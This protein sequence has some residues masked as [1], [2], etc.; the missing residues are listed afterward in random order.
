MTIA[1]DN[2]QRTGYAAE[3]VANAFLSLARQEGRAL[4]QM[5]VH[6]L[7]FI[8]H[9]FTL[10]LLGRPLMYNTVHAWRG[11][12]VVRR[13]WQLWGERGTRPI[14]EALP[15]APGEPDLGGDP[16]A[17]DVIRSVWEAYG[18]MDGLELSRLT[19]RSGSPWSQVYGQPTDLIPDQVTREY[20][21]ALARSA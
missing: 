10:A 9:G 4:T 6:K 7:V 2:P 21:T 15:V 1:I 13:L 20:Y 18:R 14:E 8:A 5:Q 11:G 12:P 3:V 17:S 19:H 16:E